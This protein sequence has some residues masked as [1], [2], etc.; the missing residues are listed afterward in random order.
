[1][2]DR[3]V[4]VSVCV[5]VCVRAYAHTN[6]LECVRWCVWVR[7]CV[8]ARACN[9]VDI[10]VAAMLR[11]SFVHTHFTF[12]LSMCYSHAATDALLMMADWL[13]SCFGFR[14]LFYNATVSLVCMCVYVLYVCVYVGGV[15]LYPRGGDAAAGWQD[16][17][18]CLQTWNLI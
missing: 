3:P 10:C 7:V 6:L 14:A 5:R 11:L 17:D 2:S 15:F 4:G 1:M 8:F 9:C 18:V 16:A 13:L 12:S